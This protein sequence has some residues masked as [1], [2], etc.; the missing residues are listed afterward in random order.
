[1]WYVWKS[2][3]DNAL[4]LSNI[5]VG[6]NP[7]VGINADLYS[8]YLSSYVGFVSQKRSSLQ[9]RDKY[10]LALQHA[11]LPLLISASS[12]RVKFKEVGRGRYGGPKVMS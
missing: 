10:M 3:R 11:Q 7:F 12:A 4:I 2:W 1:M 8:E 5:F 6:C 9:I